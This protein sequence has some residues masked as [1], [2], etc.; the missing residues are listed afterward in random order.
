VAPVPITVAGDR[1]RLAQVAHNLV[2]NALS[3]TPPGTAVRVS[4]SAQ[5]G[6]GVIQVSDE[7][8]GLDPARAA[9]VFDRFYRGDASRSSEGTGLGLAIVRAIAVSSGG[10][11]WV[12]STPGSGAVFTV[13]IPLVDQEP[14]APPAPSPSVGV[15]D[16]AGQSPPEA[17]EHRDGER[18]APVPPTAADHRRQ[19][20]G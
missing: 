7:G 6:M 2:R 12:T 16:P 9:Q 13:E 11:A 3:H 20:T 19:F 17:G 8:P 5:H 4:V 14:T 10:D 15:S 18:P 1:D